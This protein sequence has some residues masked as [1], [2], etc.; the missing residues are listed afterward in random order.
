MKEPLSYRQLQSLIYVSDVLNSSLNIDSIIHSILQTTI[1]VIDAADGGVLFL[2]DELSDSLIAQSTV[3]FDPLILNQV[4]LKPGESMT[5][6]TFQKK[7]CL[8]FETRQKVE[9]T[10]RTLS[11]AN[12]A[13]MEQSIPYY[14]YS[15]LCAPIFLKDECIGVITLDSFNKEKQFTE[16]DI[17]LL[18]AICHQAA[19]AIERGRFYQEKEQSLLKLEAMN[20]KITQH[21]EMLSRSVQLHRDLADLVLQGKGLS[22]IMEYLKEATGENFFLYDC[23][24]ALIASSMTEPFS[25][26]DIIVVKEFITDILNK[27]Q[28]RRQTGE[29]VFR[30]KTVHMLTF[31]IGLLPDLFGLLTI[32]SSKPMN[33]INIAAVEHAST[34]ISLELLKEEAI[35][36]VH[37]KVKGD[38]L[39]EVLHG[40]INETILHHAKL[41]HLYPNQTF[42]VARLKI[43]TSSTQIQEHLLERRRIAKYIQK[44]LKRDYPD[45][46]TVIQHDQLIFLFSLSNK[47]EKEQEIRTIKERFQI[48]LHKLHEQFPS[49][50]F[51]LGIGRWKNGLEQVYLSAKEANECLKFLSNFSVNEKILCYSDLGL[52]RLLLQNSEEQ[53]IDFIYDQLRPLI[54]ESKGKNREFIETLNTYI[55]NNMNVKVTAEKLHVHPNTLHYRLN[56]I[57]KILNCDFGDSHQ[58]LNLQMA[59]ELY[60]LFEGKMRLF[61]IHK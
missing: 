40:R 6:L 11:P 46:F 7:E 27:Q 43:S 41:L 58:L 15:T 32:V 10:T 14:P 38:F 56:R 42:L 39:D 3:G 61:S 22:S 9:E 20:I 55:K 24:G 18:K 51:H 52:Y 19:I 12:I 13:L 60:S 47:L 49:T 21:N 23:N 45:S 25:D 54:K 31:P 59:L 37:Q 35:F 8:L 29:V 50:N 2:Y 4:R 28:F 57:Q 53:I 17:K 16:E 1:S 34:V 36:D 30:G 44:L 5:G 33:E 48:L 26:E